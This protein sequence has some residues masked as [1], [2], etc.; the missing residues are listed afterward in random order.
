MLIVIIV[1]D[2]KISDEQFDLL[3]DRL[4]QLKPDSK[5]LTTGW[6]FEVEGDKIK[7]KYGLVGS[8][9]KCK[10]FND[11][12]DRF[13]DKLVYLSPKLDGLSCVV[14][15][16][17]GK[18]VKAITRG[19]GI[20]GKDITEK[21]KLI[22]GEEI[23]DKQFRGAVRGELI[24]HKNNWDHLL[25]KY[26]DLIAPRNFAAGIINRKDIDEDIQYI[27]LVVYKIVGQENKP[28]WTNR[29]DNINWL[30]K[31]FKHSIPEFYFPILNKASWDMYNE[32]VFQ[33][34]KK[35]GYRIRWFSVN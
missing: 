14:Y 28:I 16:Q 25:K 27:D 5:V 31:N 19:N 11:F 4:R 8:L 9:D 21:L 10:S 7:H 35:L 2:T 6:G 20:Y 15:Y 34:F 13:K 1:G 32:N 29:K 33:E 18:L 30:S 3:V 23:N 24:I 12:P 17:N 22:V 26:K